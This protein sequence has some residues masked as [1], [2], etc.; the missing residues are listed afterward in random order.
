MGK[1]SLDAA[2][3]LYNMGIV[4]RCKKEGA[5]SLDYLYKAI[6]IKE[7]ILG[8]ESLDVAKAHL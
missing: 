4:Y 6:E 2:T 8:K 3:S 7:K 1:E 5:K